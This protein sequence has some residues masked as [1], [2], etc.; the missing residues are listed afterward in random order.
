MEHKES[1]QLPE[2]GP[3]ELV[4]DDDPGKNREHSKDS[5]GG[6]GEKPERA[7]GHPDEGDS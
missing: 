3:E 2:A 1:D 6:A 7:T 4:P 5:D